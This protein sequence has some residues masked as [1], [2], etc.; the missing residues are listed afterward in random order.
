MNAPPTQ[1]QHHGDRGLVVAVEPLP[2]PAI[3]G[4]R[5]LLAFSRII[6]QFAEEFFEILSRA[7]IAAFACHHDDL[8]RVIDFETRQSVIHLVVERRRHGVAL[9]RPVERCPGDA[10]THT[11][12]HEIVIVVGHCGPPLR[13]SP[14]QR[15]A[16]KY[17]SGSARGVEEHCTLAPSSSNIP[18]V[19]RLAERAL[20]RGH[21]GAARISYADC[22]ARRAD[23]YHCACCRREI[24]AQPQRQGA[25]YG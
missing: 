9:L 24:A 5:R 21:G 18:V 15:H 8:D 3:G 6:V 11:D 22:L 17:L 14:S 13:R 2:A 19:P 1:Y 10:V 25:G 4:G 23:L 7:E 16:I 20:P 12:L